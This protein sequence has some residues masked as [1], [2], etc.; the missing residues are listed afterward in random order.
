MNDL[1]DKFFTV[2]MSFGEEEALDELLASSPEAANRFAEKAAEVYARYGL[3]DLGP[4]SNPGKN[5][6]WRV[7]LGLLFFALALAGG[8]GWWRHSRNGETSSAAPA[9]SLSNPSVG[10]KAAASSEVSLE[11]S[12]A[13]K[14]VVPDS[15]PITKNPE[16]LSGS[17]V[18]DSF[19]VQAVPISMNGT[20]PAG[21]PP[22][23]FS[24]AKGYSRLKI[25]V[26]I[27]Q[28][29]PVTV[30]ILDSHGANV[31]EVY[32]GYLP[33]GES[34]FTWDGK[35]DDG[36]KALPGGYQI[37]TLSPGQVQTQAFQIEPKNKTKP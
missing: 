21:S 11:K 18:P 33:A 37:K 23:D 8:L 30:C 5:A 25:K 15:L 26:A 20:R 9:L 35:R 19:P 31:K 2:D 6:G 10:L 28:A 1:V 13:K 12:K 3:P 16:G 27:S 14:E 36:R 17:R 29:G 22:Q 7:R 4:D 32:A 24:P 34:S